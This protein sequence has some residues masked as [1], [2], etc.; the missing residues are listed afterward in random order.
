[1][2]V[3]RAIWAGWKRFAHRLGMINTAILLTITYVLIFSVVHLALRLARKDPLVTR[4][5]PGQSL[6]TKS[7]NLHRDADVL[8]QHRRQF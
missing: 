5:A 6:W 1:M 7:E 2:Q 3:W 4:H 8:V